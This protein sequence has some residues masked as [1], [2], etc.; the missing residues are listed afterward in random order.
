MKK[1]YPNSFLFNKM[2]IQKGIENANFIPKYLH[3]SWPF[4]VAKQLQLSSP[5]HISESNFS[6]LIN[7]K[8]RNWTYLSNPNSNNAVIVD[9]SGLVYT[10]EK[11]F[12]VDFWISNTDSLFTPSNSNDISQLYLTDSNS[13]LTSF[14]LSQLDI[15]SHVIFS[16]LPGNYDFAFCNYK[17]SNNTKKNIKFSF[18]IAIR[19]F[20]CEGVTT[21]E[22]IHYLQSGTFIVNNQIGLILD[23]K[24]DNIVCLASQDGDVS[25]HFN[26]LEMIFD[27][28]CKSKKASAFAEYRLV[29]APNETISL[30][31]KLPCITK[32]FSS[33]SHTFFS[34]K[35]SLDQ[36][37]KTYQPFIFNDI[38]KEIAFNNSDLRHKDLT[39]SIPD[40]TLNNFLM[41]Q[42]SYLISSM[43]PQLFKHGYYQEIN[44]SILDHLF[45]IKNLYIAGYKPVLYSNI[46]SISYLNQVYDYLKR[47]KIF[48]TDLD[49]WFEMIHY[50][51]N[52]NIITIT[53]DCY[54]VLYKILLYGINQFKFYS[55]DFKT[56]AP[57]FD[58]YSSQKTTFLSDLIGLHGSIKWFELLTT[59][60]SFPLD[61]RINI[62]E[63][64]QYNILIN[65]SINH[66]CELV[67]KTI[68]FKDIVPVTT[69]Q[70]INLNLIK[71][72]SL[73]ATYFPKEEN[74]ITE[75]LKNIKNHL[76]YNHL[77]FSMIKPSGFSLEH[78]LEY[79]NLL[80]KLNPTTVFDVVTNLLACST[81]TYTFPDVIHPT[82]NGGSE[83]DGH[84]IKHGVALAQYVFDS[85]INLNKKT[86][87]LFVCIPSQWLTDHS[88]HI[89]NYNV[90]SETI[91]LSIKQSPIETILEITPAKGKS[92][93]FISINTQN[94]FKSFILN[95]KEII[96]Q[97][98]TIKIPK[99]ET[100]IRLIKHD[101]N[102]N[103]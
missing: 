43:H 101:D 45:F 1:N 81:S 82:T 87:A 50:C 24:P 35:L 12:S 78:N 39:F 94:Q 86:L 51:N 42:Y 67:S 66:Y 57:R 32:Q 44:H 8:Y 98:D 36:I 99:S 73:Y 103:F 61:K 28:H 33:N 22:S 38:L 71:T 11:P 20:D 56:L 65:S 46:F 40:K 18:Y 41:A 15:E 9:P 54:H 91:S 100:C 77:I 93:D 85:I 25:E 96:I 68:Y 53:Q 30:S 64:H 26:K 23:Q 62:N 90:G 60:L 80:L 63:L 14:S 7:T 31:Y 2:L 70:S 92:F 49:R 37:K 3:R 55:H 19:P 95:D 17:I 97:A 52:A 10:K 58:M 79:I 69:T 89:S 13:V 21:V 102:S 47:K 48:F 4:W 27:A 88:W 74:R 5:P 6:G 75:S 16:H 83:G 76:V 72:L 59:E 34:K 84:N 29:I